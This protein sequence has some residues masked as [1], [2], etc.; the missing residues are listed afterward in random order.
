MGVDRAEA[1]LSEASHV[2]DRRLGGRVVRLRLLSGGELEL[3]DDVPSTRA[4]CPK[5]RPCP[6]WRC[7]YHLWR[8]DPCD[9]QGRPFHGR[10]PPTTL[11]PRWLETPMP[12]SC[13]LD[14]ADAVTAGEHATFATIGRSLGYFDERMAHNV[15][16]RA[17]AAF[18]RAGGELDPDRKRSERSRRRRTRVRGATT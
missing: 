16:D 12:A 7:R 11:Q 9:R 13:A 18:R 17:E 4:D 10:R 3:R 5:A 6:H 1:A 2:V 15:V 14:V 8:I